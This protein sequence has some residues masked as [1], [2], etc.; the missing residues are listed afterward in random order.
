MIRSLLELIESRRG[1]IPEVLYST[2]FA[3]DCT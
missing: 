2:E 1:L 3:V